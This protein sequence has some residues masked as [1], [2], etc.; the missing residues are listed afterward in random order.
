MKHQE[1][2]Q[3]PINEFLNALKKKKD[4]VGIHLYSLRDIGP[5][6]KTRQGEFGQ[7]IYLVTF[8]HD[9]FSYFLNL[10]EMRY[11]Y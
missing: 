5:E 6:D 11:D 8:L 10:Y 3:P 4:S 2:S 7:S 1:I 9:L